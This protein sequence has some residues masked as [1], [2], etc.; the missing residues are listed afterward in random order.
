MV[1]LLALAT[2][3]GLTTLLDLAFGEALV[4]TAGA[5]DFAL[6]SFLATA[7]G[8][9]VLGAGFFAAAAGLDDFKTGFAALFLEAVFEVSFF[10]AMA[11]R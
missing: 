6:T 2:L 5:L 1:A 10:A 11:Q 3:L 4:F 9:P 7:A 8:L